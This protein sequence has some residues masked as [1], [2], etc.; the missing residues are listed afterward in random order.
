MRAHDVR[1]V[2]LS[3]VM[4]SNPGGE[5]VHRV[6]MYDIVRGQFTPQGLGKW[7]GPAETHRGLHRKRTDRHPI[8]SWASS[9]RG[10]EAVA[11]I[12][13]G[14][15]DDRRMAHPGEFAAQLDAGPWGPAVPGSETSYYVQDFQ[16]SGWSRPDGA[17]PAQI[18]ADQ[19]HDP[20][21][22]DVVRAVER[23]NT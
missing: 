20:Q 7:R 17:V 3:G 18:S 6:N 22:P 21:R 5:Q 16:S 19:G 23:L 1:N 10:V 2:V 11:P 8:A 4:C 13:V 15:I 9:S 12:D 14:R